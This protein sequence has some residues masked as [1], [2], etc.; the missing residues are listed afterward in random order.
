MK[1]KMSEFDVQELSK[2][3]AQIRNQTQSLDPDSYSDFLQIQAN[4]EQLRNIRA[5]ALEYLN[6]DKPVLRLVTS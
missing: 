3:V 2:K 6:K 1:P 4:N 5:L